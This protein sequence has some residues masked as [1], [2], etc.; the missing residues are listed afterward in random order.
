MPHI[1]MIVSFQTEDVT[2]LADA[3]VS[4]RY[5]TFDVPSVEIAEHYSTLV[6]RALEFASERIAK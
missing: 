1:T 5:L 2:P 3:L 4:L 6:I